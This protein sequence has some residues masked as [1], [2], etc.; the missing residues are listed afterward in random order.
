MLS[1]I[2]SHS[3]SAFDPFIEMVTRHGTLG[4]TLVK[5]KPLSGMGSLS[6]RCLPAHVS[7]QREHD[8]VS[9]GMVIALL[10]ELHLD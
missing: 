8:R 1:A 2:G 3:Q 9:L 6:P 7:K 10:V 4:L 5:L